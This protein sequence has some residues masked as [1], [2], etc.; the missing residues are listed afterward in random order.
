MKF[1]HSS[2]DLA[3]DHLCLFYDEIKEESIMCHQ[4]ITFFSCIKC[5]VYRVTIEESSA[6]SYSI[7]M[8]SRRD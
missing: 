5:C 4:M 3:I 1:P 2:Y 7:L 8:L 6:E